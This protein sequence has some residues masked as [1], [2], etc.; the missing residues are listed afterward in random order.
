MPNGSHANG[1]GLQWGVRILTKWF[2]LRAVA[3][4]ALLGLCAVG[5]LTYLDVRDIK[6]AQKEM[7]LPTLADHQ[8]KIDVLWEARIRADERRKIYRELNKEGKDQ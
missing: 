2:D 8:E 4:A 3:T 7:V 5:M 1:T 6:K